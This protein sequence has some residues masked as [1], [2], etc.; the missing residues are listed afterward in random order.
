MT[1]KIKIAIVVY[2]GSNCERD[3]QKGLA[4]IPSYEP[5]FIS[6]R[7]KAFPEGTKGVL[8]P[9]GFSYGDYL[10]PGVMAKS[11]PLTPALMEEAEKGTPL[12]GICNGFQ[13]LCELGLLPGVLVKNR[14]G[15]F[16]CRNSHL[17]I[18]P[19]SS[20]FLKGLAGRVISL[21]LAHKHGRY[22][23]SAPEDLQKQ[24]GL[25]YSND[26]G[27]TTEEANPNGSLKAIAGI[28]NSSGS[29]LGLMPHPERRIFPWSGG[30]E[31][32]EILMGFQ[33]FW[34]NR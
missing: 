14:D 16:I 13:I 12:L 26:R 15:K 30:Q 8:L 27:E 7:E 33:N 17:K 22:Y 2:P 25:V 24:I 3:C 28:T 18:L 11:S 19:N 20:P 23:C 34:Q 4:S 21:P 31:G 5:F 32:R 6:Y 1:G 9:G 10:R 29:I